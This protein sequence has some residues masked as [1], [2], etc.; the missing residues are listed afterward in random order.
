MLHPVSWLKASKDCEFISEFVLDVLKFDAR[1]PGNPNRDIFWYGNGHY[2]LSNIIQFM[3]SYED[4]WYAPMHDFDAPPG[5][6]NTGVD[7]YGEYLSHPGFLRFFEDYELDCLAS[8]IDLPTGG[9]IFGAGGS[10]KFQ[11]FNRKGF[12]GRPHPDLVHHKFGHD[13]HEWS[14][15]EFWLSDYVGD[16]SAVY[17]DRAGYHRSSL[18]YLSIGLRPKCTIGMDTLVEPM[19]DGSGFR[20]IPFES[21]KSKNRNTKVCTDEE[22]MQLMGLL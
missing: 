14:F 13:M 6:P 21:V 10:P 8:R 11:L 3:N 19:Q 15:C 2:E 4:D 12:R 1:E 9:N 17:V 20:I 7:A 16:H 22:F 18:P 5:N